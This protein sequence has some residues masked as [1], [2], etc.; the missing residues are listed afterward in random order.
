V[1]ATASIDEE[2]VRIKG[3]RAGG[4]APFA[5]S[6]RSRYTK[7]HAEILEKEWSRKR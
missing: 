7:E 5:I 6:R 3:K 2:A 1:F 4:G